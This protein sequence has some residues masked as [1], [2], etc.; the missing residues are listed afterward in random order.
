MKSRSNADLATVARI[1]YRVTT[2]WRRIRTA[3]LWRWWHF[4]VSL[5]KS[6]RITIQPGVRMSVFFG[7][8]LSQDI[9]F[10][11]YEENE[12]QFLN[13]YLRPGDAF[14]D[15]G[16]NIGFYTLIAARLVQNQGH[17]Y[18]FEPAKDTYEKLS[19]NVRL[20]HFSQVE[21]FRN[22]ISSKAATLPLRASTGGFHAWDSLAAPLKGDD[23]VSQ[24]VDAISWDE[25]QD[26][27]NTDRSIAMMK[28]DVEGWETHVV[29]GAGKI[30]SDSKAPVLQ[31]ELSDQAL[32]NAGSSSEALCLKLARF[33]YRMFI[34][35]AA[36]KCL[37]PHTLQ[38]SYPFT[39]RE[40]SVYN[41]IFI[42][43]VLMAKE[44]LLAKS[45]KI[46]SD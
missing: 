42:K 28:I 19:A 33:G 44:R 30:L 16:A 7:D 41:F 14:V 4:P 15:I 43:D 11:P 38:K 46:L 40:R 12:R 1:T 18:A 35:D 21:C 29:E 26:T 27:H 20:N 37:V 13:A 6:T 24:T 31:V 5:R 8:H 34:P 10:G 17:V 23:Q 39:F 36:G 9:F 45:W 32:A 3:L 2:L 22:A 25:F